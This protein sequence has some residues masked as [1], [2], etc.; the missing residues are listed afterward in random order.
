M[1]V[2]MG[3][4]TT[5][6]GVLSFTSPPSED[7]LSYM[8]LSILGQDCRE[9]PEWGVPDSLT[10]VDLEVAYDRSGNALGLQWNGAEKTYHMDGLINVVVM[11]MRRRCPDFGV[12]GHLKA[13]GEDGATWRIKIADDGF[14]V[15]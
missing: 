7:D 10:Y 9:H 8:E 4:S 2:L 3:Y 11:L 12:Q 1:V 6:I 15:A 5:F 13:V 14:A